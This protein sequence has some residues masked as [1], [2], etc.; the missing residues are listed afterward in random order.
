MVYRI[1]HSFGGVWEKLLIAV[2][3]IVIPT[4]AVIPA[5]FF[6][7]LGDF[8]VNADYSV[9]VSLAGSTRQGF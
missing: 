8:P 6:V 2:A 7:G 4:L 9:Y 5:K 3:G 1:V